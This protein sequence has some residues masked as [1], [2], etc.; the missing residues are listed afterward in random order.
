MLTKI[1]EEEGEVTCYAVIKLLLL[2]GL[3]YLP[4]CIHLQ[5]VH[6]IDHDVLV[7]FLIFSHS[8]RHSEPAGTPRT[9]VCLTA[10]LP[11][12]THLECTV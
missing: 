1:I 9:H 5:Y 10:R 8:E 4:L 12:R 2:V 7:C 3:S 11:P 6:H